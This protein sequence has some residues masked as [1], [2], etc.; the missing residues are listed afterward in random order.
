MR[1]QGRNLAR[2]IREGTHIRS[3]VIASLQ[4][5]KLQLF[6][7]SASLLA[8][9]ITVRLGKPVLKSSS[10][11]TPFLCTYISSIQLSLVIDTLVNTD[12]DFCHTLLLYAD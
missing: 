4:M 10:R 2:Y 11:V 6:S 3:I 7:G 1:F 9:S 5:K 12:K 8:I